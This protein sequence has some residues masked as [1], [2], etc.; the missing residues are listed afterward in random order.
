MGKSQTVLF[1]GIV[2]DLTTMLME[3][4]HLSTNKIRLNQS[5]KEYWDFTAAKTTKTLYLAVNVQHK[6]CIRLPYLLLLFVPKI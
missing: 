6:I 1:K 2:F 4:V 5:L 3:T